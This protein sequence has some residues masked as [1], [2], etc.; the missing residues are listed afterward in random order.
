MIVSHTVVVWFVSAMIVGVSVGWGAR[1]IYLLTKHLRKKH[2]W[3]EPAAWRDQIFGSFM[4]LV[5]VTFGML[6]VLRYHLSH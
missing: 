1:D 3:D 5:V 4:G 6:G 2:E